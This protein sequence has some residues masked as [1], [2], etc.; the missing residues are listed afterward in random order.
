MRPCAEATL[1]E[2]DQGAFVLDTRNGNCFALNS[3]GL[4]V[5]NSLKDGKSPDEIVTILERRFTNVPRAKLVEDVHTFIDRL[6]SR[7]L[8]AP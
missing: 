5:W 2:T 3:L 7:R 4:H 1:A 6:A 8:V